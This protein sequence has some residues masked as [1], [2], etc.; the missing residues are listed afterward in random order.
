MSLIK[1]ISGFRGTIGGLESTALTPID[2]VKFTAAYS[3]FIK[4]TSKKDK[5]KIIIGISNKNFF[6]ICLTLL[7]CPLFILSILYVIIIHKNIK[8]VHTKLKKIKK[9]LTI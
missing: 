8:K 5:L 9:I 1:S 7:K 4:E 3:Q 2:I 6:I